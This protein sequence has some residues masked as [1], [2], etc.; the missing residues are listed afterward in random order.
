MTSEV[1]LNKFIAESGI[2]SRRK[3]DEYIKEGRVEVNGLIVRDYFLQINPEKDIVKVDGERIKVQEKIYILLN[4]PKGF[5]C[6]LSDEKNRPKVV[7]LVKINKRLYPV[8]RLDFNTTGALILTNDGDFANFIISSRN[9][10][11]RVYR[12]VLNKPLEEED[13]ERLLKGIILDKRKSKFEEIL[14]KSKKSSR[15]LLVT[16]TEGRNHFVKNMFKSLGYFV[17]ELHRESIANLTVNDLPIGKWRYISKN[18]VK[19]I[20]ELF[21]KKITKSKKDKTE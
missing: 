3:A 18:E 9:K 19:K 5:V 7:D 2:C 13:R 20:Y 11:P 1:R 4:K 21:E 6:T 15:H 16:A 10:I 12:V 14:L 8:G 17:E